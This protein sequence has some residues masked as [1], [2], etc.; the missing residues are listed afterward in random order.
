MYNGTIKCVKI[1]NKTKFKNFTEGKTYAVTEGR[2]TNDTG[3]LSPRK[4]V[5]AYESFSDLQTKWRSGILWEESNV[6]QEPA[7]V[8]N[9]PECVP[10]KQESPMMVKCISN[11]KSGFVCGKV[12]NVVNGLIIDN[13]GD[14][15]PFGGL[16]NPNATMKDVLNLFPGMFEEFIDFP[17]VLEN[18]KN[19]LSD[20][21]VEILSYP[22]DASWWHCK[23]LALSTEGK[24]IK[25]PPDERWKRKA[26]LSRH[27]IIRCL[28]F[29][30]KLRIPY[31]VSVHFSRHKI[32]V[33]H[34]VTSQRNDRQ[35]NFDRL[36]AR[37]DNMVT[38]RMVLNA[39]A[40]MQMANMRLCNKADGATRKVMQK[41]CLRVEELMPEFRGLLVP[42]CEWYGF[43][44][45]FYP[46]GRKISHAASE[47]AADLTI[48]T[49]VSQDIGN[50]VEHP[51]HYNV[52]KIEVIDF[53]H[54]QKLGFDL[55]NAIKYICRAEHKGKPVEDLKKASYYLNLHL[56]ALGG[57]ADESK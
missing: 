43:C 47:V 53:I 41:I 12:Y 22:D 55:G 32:G 16:P 49:P 42:K 40:L 35:S 8:H 4:G 44:N 57:K 48:S 20:N 38:H 54:D 51:N 13:D 24:T 9:K 28:M 2:I 37:Q 27:S 56:E 15:R 30:I 34:F 31:Y 50:P 7:E 29:D 23:E 45:E 1:L 26:L 52:G 25:N 21:S 18:H 10:H 14:S 6:A 39:E 5:P 36:A 11:N 46:C 17:D 19:V 3:A 33:E